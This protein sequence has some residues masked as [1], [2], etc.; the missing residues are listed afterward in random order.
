[1]RLKLTLTS[2][3]SPIHDQQSFCSIIG[4]VLYTIYS[5]LT[6]L[7]LASFLGKCM[8]NQLVSFVQ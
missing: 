6:K 3:C 8:V 4:R 1:M 5:Y 2:S 7:I